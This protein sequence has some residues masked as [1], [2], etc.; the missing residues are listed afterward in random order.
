VTTQQL[1]CGK[2][3]TLRQ[4]PDATLSR[5]KFCVHIRRVFRDPITADLIHCKVDARAGTFERLVEF[6]QT[7]AATDPARFNF[8][9]HSFKDDYMYGIG[10]LVSVSLD[11]NTRFQ[12]RTEWRAIPSDG[13]VSMLEASCAPQ[14][15][16]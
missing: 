14:S 9:N 10:C 16:F 11:L 13:D 15:T 4:L 2:G 3:K 1:P 5:I 6:F 8:K 7:V 12:A